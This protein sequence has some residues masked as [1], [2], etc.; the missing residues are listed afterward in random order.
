MRSIITI[1]VFE[2]FLNSHWI[3][4]KSSF[5][6]GIRSGGRSQDP[7]FSVCVADPGNDN[8][9]DDDDDDDEKKRL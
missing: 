9:D 3:D 6:Q 4:S 2:S 1:L 7:S 5:I 8:D